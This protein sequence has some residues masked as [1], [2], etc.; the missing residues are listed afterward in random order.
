MRVK[1]YK[2]LASANSGAEFRDDNRPA[3]RGIVSVSVR[4][5]EAV[6][7]AVLTCSC[8]TTFVDQVGS[9]YVAPGKFILLRCP[10]L[11][12]KSTA[13]SNREKE[14]VSLM[15]RANQDV[16]GPVINTFIYKTDLDTVRAELAELKKTEKE[17]NC[18][19]VVAAAKPP[20]TASV[21]RSDPNPAR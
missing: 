15:D 5:C 11:A 13:A 2:G 7:L 19:N 3:E 4:I 20:P 9:L 14:L 21:P 17:K 12:A 6:L 10:D 16:A 8:S 1:F 18:S